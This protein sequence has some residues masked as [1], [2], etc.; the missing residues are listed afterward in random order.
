MKRKTFL[1]LLATSFIAIGIFSVGTTTATALTTNFTASGSWTCPAGVTMVTV[2]CWGGGGAG[3]SARRS[4][5][6]SGTTI[7]GGGGAGGA[8]AIKTNYTVT[9]SLNYTVTVG[10]G[11]VAPNTTIF[12]DGS[13]SDG[14]DSWFDTAATV[15][16]KGG[17]GG[18]R[19]HGGGGVDAV[20]P[21][22]GLVDQ[23]H[24][25]AAAS[26]GAWSA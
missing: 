12:T 9:P 26:A 6:A 3:G 23:R 14:Q 19:A 17:G 1:R 21:V 11:G 13:R 7:D 10:L 15:L 4:S 16:A 22:E 18:L 5:G 25:S 20:V 8:Y 2:E 24:G